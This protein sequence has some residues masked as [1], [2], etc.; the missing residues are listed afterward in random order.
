MPV[1]RLHPRRLQGPIAALLDRAVTRAVVR[2]HAPG[3]A[4]ADDRLLI[5]RAEAAAER[6]AHAPMGGYFQEP[7]PMQPVV[8]Q[9]NSSGFTEL[10]WR[11]NHE[12]Y[13]D[14]LEQEYLAYQENRYARVRLYRRRVPRPVA[15]AVHG[16]MGGS[17][18]L[19]QRLWPLSWLDELGF[20]AALFALPFHGRRARQLAALPAFPQ[21]NIL[22]N[23]EGFRQSVTDLRDLLNYL[24]REGH[25][26]VGLLGMSL[27]GYIAA[28]AATIES[29]FAFLVPIVPLACLAD[30]VRD[31]G[32]LPRGSEQALYYQATLRRAYR[33]V[34][35]LTRPPQIAPNRVLVLAGKADRITP[36]EHARHLARHFGAPLEAWSGG[37]LLQ[38]GRAKSLQRVA[39]VLRETGYRS[40]P[41]EPR[42]CGEG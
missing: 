18:A 4:R 10:A 36:A 26:A 20:D 1:S 16:Y 28:L 12:L 37:H 31:Q 15:I 25:P 21:S 13:L 38:F 23:T 22:F 42:R 29:R 8:T 17:F 9:S 2:R 6:F 7:R 33:L 32:H 40:V 24:L 39:S 27:G 30:F 34:S 19:E 11:S 41:S 3:S 14:E 35:P 5:M